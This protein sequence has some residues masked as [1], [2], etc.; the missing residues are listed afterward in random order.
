MRLKKLFHSSHKDKRRLIF[1]T[2]DGVPALP[3]QFL[4]WGNLIFVSMLLIFRA[5]NSLQMFTACIN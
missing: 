2:T 1:G 4:L 5:F 3:E